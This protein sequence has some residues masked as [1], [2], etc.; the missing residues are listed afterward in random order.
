[1]ESD[2]APVNARQPNDKLLSAGF[3]L[4]V[5]PPEQSTRVSKLNISALDSAAEASNAAIILVP[6]SATEVHVAL[7]EKLSLM[8]SAATADGPSCSLRYPVAPS[9]LLAGSSARDR[10]GVVIHRSR[11]TATKT[12]SHVRS[13]LS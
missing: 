12:T 1:M 10:K 3:D 7:V 9:R 11:T 4:W 5:Q 13:A 6:S 8:N 2:A